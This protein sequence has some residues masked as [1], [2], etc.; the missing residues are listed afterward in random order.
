[1]ST[2]SIDASSDEAWTPFGVRPADYDEAPGRPGVRVL[3]LTMRRAG[4]ANREGTDSS[5]RWLRSALTALGL[6]AAAAAAVSFAAQYR[7]VFAAK[8][9]AW[10]AALEALVPDV[11]A[12]VFAAL[13]IALALQGRRAV[14]ARA[15]NVACVGLSLGMNALAAKAGWRDMAV[16]VM[17]AAVYA[18][19]SDTLIGVI[20][21]SVLAQQGRA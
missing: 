21:A 19:A 13:G 11:G 12:A 2:N 20:R 17:P 9:V 7:L 8:G 16:W 18:L 5:A 1:M 10:A 3:N 4:R 15:L 14:R 6:L